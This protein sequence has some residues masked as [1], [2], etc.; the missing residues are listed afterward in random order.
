MDADLDQTGQIKSRD[1]VR[2]LAEVYTHDREVDA[3]LA[4]IPDMFREIDIRFLEPACGHGNF[5]VAI[6]ARKLLLITEEQ[7]GGTPHWYEFATLRA[8][9]SI[10]AV[11]I[12]EENV[13]EARERM[14]AVVDKEFADQGYEPTPRFHDALAAILSAN[15]VGGDTLRD[16]QS[17]RFL[18]WTAGDDETFVRTPSYL[19][20][21]AF[22][23]FFAPPEPLPPVHYSELTS[24][25]S[26]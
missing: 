12:S 13:V 25:T 16:A 26:L 6:L 3:M 22:D 7:H 23:L 4:L 1:R 9:A 19:E 5:L 21:P 8:V 11:D 15:L 10:Y 14:R 17:I 18:E 24:E 20:D 2:D